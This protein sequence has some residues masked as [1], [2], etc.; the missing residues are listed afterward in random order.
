MR[1]INYSINAANLPPRA[2]FSGGE[3]GKDEGDSKRGK[4]QA[5]RMKRG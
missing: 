1:G 4:C 5:G 2:E 3:I